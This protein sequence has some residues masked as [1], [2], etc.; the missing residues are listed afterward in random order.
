VT[1]EKVPTD[2]IDG[3][4]TVLTLYHNQLK[5]GIEVVR[6][7]DE[8][9]KFDC[10]EDEMNQVWTNLIH[11]AIQAMDYKG[12]LSISAK[13]NVDSITICFTDN[14]SG[15]EKDIQDKI[16]EPFFTTKKQGEGSGMGL[17]IVKRII[18]KHD[19]KI[20]FKSEL[21]KGTE[22]IISLPVK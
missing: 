15:I 19:G 8:L 9:P 18:E 1:G 22:F 17:D 13:N 3:I 21:G 10:Y 12:I 4:E 20:T 2:I 5:Q 14:G 7:Y 11:N 6:D 16:F